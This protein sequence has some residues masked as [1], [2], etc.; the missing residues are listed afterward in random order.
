[1]AMS[2]ES[3]VSAASRIAGQS[4]YVSP[5]P[6]HPIDVWLNGNEGRI[7]PPELLQ[8]VD[9]AAEILRRYPSVERLEAL[10]AARY[11]LPRARVLVTAGADDAIYR[12]CLV[13]L[14]EGR[15]IVL[16]VPTFEM[17][18]RYARLAG[19][20]LAT[21][22]WM[23]GSYPTDAVAAGVTPRT[24][25]IAV[26]SPNN[27]TGAVAVADDLRRLSRGAPRALLLVD[28]AYAEFADADLTATALALPNALVVRTLSKAWGLAGLRVGYALG[29]PDVI[30]WLRAAGNP[31]AVS[32]LSAALAE[33]W[34]TA[35]EA[36]V[37]AFVARVR[38]ERAV[39]HALL[40]ELGARPLPSQANFVLA[41]FNDA[42]GTWDGLARRGIA[43]RRFPQHT[44][45]RDFLRIT[46]PGQT[47]VFSR[48]QE[49]LRATLTAT[50][51]IRP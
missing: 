32:G 31:Y 33:A 51:R 6:P 49:A 7:A 37:C 11:G 25:M 5:A 45:L 9:H 21:T 50:T 44:E 16:P 2:I 15:D 38:A 24:G 18:E 35:G 43:V 46:C 10:I 14:D 48:L 4:P 39:L 34:L 12:A 30:G 26:V 3:G 22:P 19:A 29:P 20:R 1:M 36:E 23:S 40:D 17:L 13:V 42:A 41:C 47:S 8:S 27:P 28:L